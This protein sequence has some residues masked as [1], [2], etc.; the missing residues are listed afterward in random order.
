MWIFSS[1][2]GQGFRDVVVSVHLF[3]LGG[4]E[5]FKDVD[6]FDDVGED[7]AEGIHVLFVLVV[8]FALLIRASLEWLGCGYRGVR[9]KPHGKFNNCIR[10]KWQAD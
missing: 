10:G 3:N 7:A 1:V 9:V 4:F 8:V 5:G 2:W 6:D